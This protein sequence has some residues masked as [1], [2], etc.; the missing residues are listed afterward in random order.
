MEHRLLAFDIDG[1]LYDHRHGLDPRVVWAAR[2]A[3]RMGLKLVLATGRMFSSALPLARL[4]GLK[5]PMICYQGARICRTDGTVL[6]DR[7]LKRDLALD[8]ARFLSSKRIHV[9]AYRDERILVESDNADAATYA[10]VAGLPYQ[11]VP[12]FAQDLGE[13]TP[14]LVGVVDP[15]TMPEVL[16]AV[17]AAF[18]DRITATTSLANFLEIFDRDVDKA[19]AL[20]MVAARLKV[21]R[22]QVVAVGD[23][24]NDVSMVAWAGLGVCVEGSPAELREVAQMTVPSAAEAGVAVLIERLLMAET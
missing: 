15:R 21:P 3:H 23:A 12:S 20:E 1:T 18:G 4:L 22:R 2:R 10:A 24:L 17:R 11:V 13:T 6:F 9:N 5:T 16:A 8:V 14:K 7:G 19:R